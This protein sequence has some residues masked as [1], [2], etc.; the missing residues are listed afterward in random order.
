MNRMW[1]RLSLAFIVVTQLSVFVVVALAY[2]GV[3]GEFRRYI[4]FSGAM[5]TSDVLVQYYQK[6]GSWSG[7]DQLFTT[8]DAAPV[9]SQPPPTGAAA[10]RPWQS[11]E[12]AVIFAD[13][14]GQILFDTQH[15]FQGI[16]LNGSERQA[17]MPI[18]A[19][20]P[21]AQPL[22]YL[23]PE[24]PR[25]GPPPMLRTDAPPDALLN[26]PEQAFLDRM[27]RILLLAALIIGAIGVLTGLIISRT[28][29]SPLNK[30][31]RAARA[32][33]EHDWRLRVQAR[34]TREVVGLATAFNEMADA[35]ERAETQR[36]N[37]MADIAHELRTPLSVMR[38][39]LG[40]LLDGIYP[41]DKR[42]IATLYEETHTL[43]RLVDD[44]HELAQ[45]DAGQL[46]LK[47]EEVPL[48]AALDAT[49]AKFTI[50]AECDDTRLS[51]EGDPHGLRVRADSHRLAQVMGNLVA[52][53]LRHTAGGAVTLS[54]QPLSTS[55]G[56]PDMVQV[57]ITD[58]GEGIPPEDLAH[59]FERF[60]RVDKSRTRSSGS[61][62]LGLAIAKAWIESMGGKIGADSIPGQCS[63]FWFTLPAV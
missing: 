63:R 52:N 45:A 20:D 43:G 27:Q 62:G 39:N 15:R 51:V 49:A 58:T 35:L 31:T 57:E 16:F 13:A 17:A 48:D 10:V 30:L 32:F 44:L 7:V 29:V 1:V 55:K 38:A 25:F 3:N 37:L 34:G 24:P 12:P 18:S 14:N 60:Y 53:A 61:S 11:R 26:T 5:Q 36:R 33:A 22:G 9:P 40:A 54:A 4:F 59:I 2:T 28:L 19:N 21:S 8:S 41:L 46:A 47:I 50:A 56:Q 23:L 42:E 6:T